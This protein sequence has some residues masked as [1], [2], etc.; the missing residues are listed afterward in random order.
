MYKI[1]RKFHSEI[2]DAKVCN[3]HDN[4]EREDKGTRYFLSS[5]LSNNIYFQFNEMNK[6]NIEKKKKKHLF[7][8]QTYA[9]QFFLRRSF[10][11]KLNADIVFYG[12]TLF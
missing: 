10:L 2:K 1:I 9:E 4:L 8:S 6:I 7:F 12:L 3:N 5:I 11:D